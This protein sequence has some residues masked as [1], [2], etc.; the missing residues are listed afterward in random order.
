MY[1]C[2]IILNSRATEF[3]ENHSQLSL[4]KVNVAKTEDGL[5]KIY[6]ELIG[7]KQDNP[8]LIEYIRKHVLI[9]PDYSEPLNLSRHI[10]CCKKLGNN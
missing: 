8:K 3:E 10:K 4:E 5:V 2:L 6:W 1:Q 7:M 9:K